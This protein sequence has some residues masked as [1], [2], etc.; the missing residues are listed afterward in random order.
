[1][2]AASKRGG[3]AVGI[4]LGTTYSCVAVWRRDCGEV[5]ANDQG[6]RLTPSCVAFNST[7]RLVGEA[8]VNQAA[9]NPTN[10]IFEVKRLIGRRFSDESVQ[11]DIKLWPF[12]V[13]AGPE[14]HPMIVVQFKGEEKKFF[15]EE[16]SS[17]VLAKMRETAEVYLG[18]TIKNAV[19]TVPVYFN[20]SQRQATID[21]GTIAG[22]N[23]MRII[24]EPTAAAIAY[25]LD[26][27]SVSSKGRT[28]YGLDKMPVSSK[29][30][31]VLV[32][33]L[34]GG[35]FDVSLLSIDPGI[36]IGMG[37]FEVKAVA[38]DSHLGGA[39]FGNEMVRFCLRDFIRKH[40]KVGIRSDQR[41]LRRLKSACERAKRMLSSMPETTIEVDSLHDGIDFSVSITR[42]RFEELNK[43]IFNRFMETVEKCLFDA[44]VHKSSVNDVVL[45]GGSTR[46]PKVQSMLRDFFGGKELCCSINPDEAVAYGAAIQA[47]ILS[48]E[49]R[50]GVVGDMLLLDVIPLSLGVETRTD[51]TMNVLIP[52]NTAI[53]TKKVGVFTTYYDN[54]VSVGIKVYEG[55]SASTTGNNL[56]GE[57]VLSGILPAP[58]GIAVIDVTF[59]IDANGVLNVSA[60]DRTTGRK[61]ITITNHSGRLSKEEILR[62]VQEA[63]MYKRKG[64]KLRLE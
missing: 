12:K 11:E 10:T 58:K 8:A 14:D 3:P 37:L 22:L 29:G 21:A 25:G 15:P 59:D 35:T 62:M 48:G 27:M 33:D 24:N 7:D 28:A 64:I 57:F 39:D 9:L 42:S 32:F 53:P 61:N 44:K 56:L 2:A 23:V 41:A 50:D 30:R 17:M 45:V 13:V 63:E 26:K 16:I 38:G 31:T 4:D 52:R 1:M 40:R 60:K 19:I 55:E 49:I 34:G 6:N 18:T 43:N 5:I 47:S 20:N 36:D 46:I 54:Q 51:H